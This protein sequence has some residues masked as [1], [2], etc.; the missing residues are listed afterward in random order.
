MALKQ[1][2]E[3]SKNQN[4]QISKK[5]LKS[6]LRHICLL[7]HLMHFFCKNKEPL[8]LTPLEKRYPERDLCS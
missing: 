1:N 2:T 4:I 5:F 3:I 8:E 7:C 6:N